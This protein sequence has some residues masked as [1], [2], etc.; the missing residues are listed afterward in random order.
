MLRPQVVRPS[1]PAAQQ[2]RSWWSDERGSVLSAELVFLVSLLALG[3]I[4]GVK[5]L[6]DS[7]ITEWADFAQAI[8]N[9]DQS[10]NIPDSAPG[11]AIPDGSGF[12]DLRDFCDDGPDNGPTTFSKGGP[13]QDKLTTTYGIPPTG[14]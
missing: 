4:V 1:Q 8:G 2:P 14:E 11:M 6:R 3:L 13:N 5:S 7:A 10:Y 9:L 12:E